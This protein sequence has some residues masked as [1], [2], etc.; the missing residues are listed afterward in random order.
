MV[1]GQLRRP[2]HAADVR[3][4]R[5]RVDVRCD[6]AAADP[7]GRRLRRPVHRG[8]RLPA[9]VRSRNHRCGHRSGGDRDGSGHRAGDHRAAGHAGRAGRRRGRRRRRPRGIGHHPQ[10]RLVLG[11]A[12]RRGRGAG[13]RPGALRPRLR[14]ELL[15]DGRTRRP[16]PA[17]RPGRK[18][19]VDRRRAGDHG[20]GQ[21]RRGAGAPGGPADPGLPSRRVARPR[22]RRDVVAARHGH[23]PRLVRPVAVR[24]GDQRPDG[25]AARPRANWRSTP[26]SSTSRSSVPASSAGSWRRRPSETYRPSSRP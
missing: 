19:T 20:R 8:V 7:T 16:R 14:R 23:P 24:D 13:L 9:D 15:R 21:R 25:P 4:A 2:A 18:A 17:L 22:Q 3:A 5:A 10:R 12:G 1:P 11:R 6:P 26:T